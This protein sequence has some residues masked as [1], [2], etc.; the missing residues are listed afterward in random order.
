MVCREFLTG[1]CLDCLA[2]LQL[3][4]LGLSLSRSSRG[5]GRGRGLVGGLSL[6]RGV[7]SVS[8]VDL[9]AHLLGEGQLDG[10]AGRVG[11]AG[12]AL[13][14]GLGDN[15]DLRDGDALLLGKVIARNPGQRDGLVYT[16]LDGL[17]VDDINGG[18][19]NGEDRHVVASLLGDLLA[20][21]V[22][23]SVVAVSSVGLAD[24]DHHVLALLVEG[25]LDGLGSGGLS[26]GLVGV[27]ADL[28]VNLLSALGTD[29]A[30]NGVALLDI[31]DALAAQLNGSADSIKGRSAHISNLNNIQN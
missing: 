5:V 1:S 14:E 30:G 25:H 22:A 3:V 21:V 8:V 31:L 23:V 12:D 11:Q 15:L 10:L 26:L 20:V 13:L 16:G 19:N 29:G 24:S 17:G 4:V 6:S 7:L 2:D 28:V 18:L 9:L 27:G